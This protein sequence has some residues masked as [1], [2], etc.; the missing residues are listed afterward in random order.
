MSACFIINARNERV[1]LIV[2]VLKDELRHK[3]LLESEHLF[4]QRGYDM[5]IHDV[6]LDGL[7]VVFGIDRAGL[8]GADGETHHGCFDALYLPQVPGMTVYCPANFAELRR[9]L[10]RALYET[11]GPVAVRYPRGGEGA[12]YTGCGSDALAELA[13]DG[14]DISVGC[15]FCGT[16]YTFTPAELEAIQPKPVEE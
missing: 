10:R 5:L 11:D 2:Q 13:Q 6:S 12:Y 7:H 1:V 3:I 14:K 9:M 16:E 15:Q 8:V 4:L